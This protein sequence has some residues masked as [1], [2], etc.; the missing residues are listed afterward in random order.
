MARLELRVF[1]EGPTERRVLLVLPTKEESDL[2]DH[3]FGDKVG[4]DGI[5]ASAQGVVKLEDGYATHYIR[6]EKDNG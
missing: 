5:I 1:G 6:L 2:I 3:V 4:E